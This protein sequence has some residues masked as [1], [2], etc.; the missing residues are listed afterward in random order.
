VAWV[1]SR[2][3]ARDITLG[4]LCSG[5]YH[6]LRAAITAIPVNRVVMVNPET[7]FWSEGMSIYDRQTAELVRQPNA[8]KVMSLAAWKRLLSGQID[9]RYVLGVYAGRFSLALE[10]KFRNMARCLGIRLPNDLGLQ[11]EEMGARGVCL[12]FVFSRG[13]PGIELLKLQ[14]GTSLKRL[15]ERCRIHIVDNADHVFSKLESRMALERILSDELL[16]PP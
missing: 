16:A 11:L 1:R 12:I 15:G 4:G 8:Y 5:A 13:E 3:G 14:G 2:Y 6:S 10:S 7:F 9:I